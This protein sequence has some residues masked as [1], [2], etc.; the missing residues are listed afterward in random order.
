M[1]SLAQHPDV[2]AVRAAALVGGCDP[3][4][5]PALLHPLHVSLASGTALQ[6]GDAAAGACHPGRGGGS[7]HSQ[8]QLESPVGLHQGLSVPCS[9]LPECAK[10]SSQ[11][12]MRI[13]CAC[14]RGAWPTNLRR[15]CLSAPPA[16]PAPPVAQ[17][18][19][20]DRVQQAQ[21]QELAAR[22]AV[23]ASPGSYSL[24]TLP[25]LDSGACSLCVMA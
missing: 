19:D 18:M 14:T 6:L 17:A 15:L 22:A 10:A 23:Q 5:S 2:P 24:M 8:P 12:C 4:E 25:D 13:A 1:K 3:V 16:P 9:W 11:T 21:Q 20:R 7:C